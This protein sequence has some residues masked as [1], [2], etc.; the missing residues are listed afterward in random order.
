MCEQWWSMCKFD[1]T[2]KLNQNPYLSYEAFNDRLYVLNMVPIQ[3]GKTLVQCS[4]MHS[5]GKVISKCSLIRSTGLS[6]IFYPVRHLII[7][8][9]HSYACLVCGPSTSKENIVNSHIK[10]MVH[11]SPRLLCKKAYSTFVAWIF[12]LLCNVNYVLSKLKAA[13]VSIQIGC[14]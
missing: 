14:C 4:F 12:Y 5:R 9:F 7:S 11:F 2:K 8:T 6:S 1:I 10:H 3:L 13:R